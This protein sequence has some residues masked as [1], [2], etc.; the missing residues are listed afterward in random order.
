MS[1]VT[2]TQEKVLNLLNLS[3]RN[4]TA[5]GW[6]M[7]SK[8][9]KCGKSDK[10][11]VK[12]N[13]NREGE[14]KNH[15]SIHCFHGSCGF[16]GSEKALFK[17]MGRDDLIT[18]Y[19]YREDLG[20]LSKL[21]IKEKEEKIEHLLKKRYPPM[22][23]RRVYEDGYLSSRGF[24]KES[25]ERYNVGRS[26]IETKLRNYVIFLVIEDGEN[27]GYVA[28]IDFSREKYRVINQEREI[29]GLRPLPKYKNEGGVEF[30]EALYG[31]DEVTDKTQTVILVEGILD[32]TNMDKEMLLY[33]TDEVKCLCTFGK[34]I[35]SIQIRKIRDRGVKTV[36]L[37]YDPDA[38]DSIKQYSYNLML[39]FE[40]VFVAKLVGEKDPGDMNRQEIFLTLENL[41]TVLSFRVN[42]IKSVKIT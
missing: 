22:G 27:K 16:K 9:P 21:K 42:S 28:R 33:K 8:C 30:S 19:E 6:Y 25:F 4:R 36:I 17:A 41:E 38:I 39:E 31:I 29:Q 23:Y 10:F 15:V 2:T 13:E 26:K 3:H 40:K 18:E 35:S 7:G 20:T 5:K 11:G 32:K 34:K 14:Y 37:M 24:D 12:L 1:D